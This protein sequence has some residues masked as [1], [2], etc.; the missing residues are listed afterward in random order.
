MTA[1][2]RLSSL[3]VP[4]AQALKMLTQEERWRFLL[5]VLREI[6]RGGK[7]QRVEAWKIMRDYFNMDR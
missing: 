5:G 7:P 4:S 3:C 6:N 2:R 1:K